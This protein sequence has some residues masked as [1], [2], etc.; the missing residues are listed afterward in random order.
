MRVAIYGRLLS[1]QNTPYIRQFFDTLSKRK[2]D[3][4]I[5]DNY[6][7][8]IINKI[9]FTDDP[10]TFTSHDE[11]A[12]KVDYLF[13]L[14]GDGTL[15][16]TV[17]LVRDSNIPIIG[18]NIG[19]LGFLA[20]LGKEEIE[21]AISAL[22]EGTYVI[23]KRTLVHLDSNKPILKGVNYA[24][25]EITIHKKDTASLINIHASLNGEFLNSF[26]VD[27]LIV[28]T[29]TGSTGYSLSCGGPVISP[30]SKALIITPI[31]PHNMNVRPLVVP[32]DTIISV[33]IEGRDL[34]A[35][36]TLDSRSETIDDT[37]QLSISKEKF[38]IS[39]V[40]LQGANFLTTLRN[41]LMWGVDKRN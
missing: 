23:D 20:S 6:C 13:S 24:L 32:D 30:A 2:I 18:I 11:I 28:S 16:E 38:M 5:Y 22:E 29:P 1:D 15:L 9:D 8:E 12:G 25:N 35:L 41:K 4:V 19:R 33:K 26:W 14:G 36:C 39:L 3:F 40:S 17:T 34:S 31:A 27:G 10:A 37:F 7:K 21:T